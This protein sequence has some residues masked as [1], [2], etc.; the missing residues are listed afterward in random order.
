M[1]EQR[2]IYYQDHKSSSNLAVTEFTDIDSNFC[3]VRVVHFASISVPHLRS[4]LRRQF[5]VRIY[6]SQTF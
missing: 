2:C 4:M 3:Y 6:G 1:K 5:P